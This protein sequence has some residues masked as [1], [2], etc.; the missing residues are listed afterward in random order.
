MALKKLELYMACYHPVQA[1][2]NTFSDFKLKKRAAPFFKKPSK[3]SL[4]LGTTKPLPLPC[5]KCI[6]CR[7]DYSRQWAMRGTAELSMVETACFLTLTYNNEN[8]PEGGTLMK[9]HYQD[10]IRALRRRGYKFTYMMAG[11]YGDKKGR[12]HYHAIIY[13][14]DFMKGA[15][16]APYKQSK[17][18][19]LYENAK[20]TEIW[21]KGN[22]IIAQATTASIQYVASYITK[23]KSGAEAKEHYGG[24]L[25]E[26]MQPSLKTPIGKRWLEKYWRDVFPS[27]QFIFNGVAVPPPKY[28]RKWYAKHFPQNA[29]ELSVKRETLM[30]QKA[31][32]FTPE[33]LAARKEVTLANFKKYKR[34]LDKEL[35]L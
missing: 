33:R 35:S 23:K 17:Q 15:T 4:L 34:Q 3:I 19:P 12:P 16:L 6:G 21:G 24:R 14:Q 29:L 5:G 30:E 2:R 7:I 18:M 1:W 22:V 31:H 9:D 10:F 25:P 20:L 13:G 28:F 32:E 8:L 26:F 27:D 11:E